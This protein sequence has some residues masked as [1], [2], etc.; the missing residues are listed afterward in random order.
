[1]VLIT[2]ASGP[3]GAVKT[4]GGKKMPPSKKYIQFGLLF[5]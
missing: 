4:D 2:N 5:E 1:M 3:F